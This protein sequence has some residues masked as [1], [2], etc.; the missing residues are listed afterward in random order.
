[1]CASGLGTLAQ[2]LDAKVRSDC[3]QLAAL[4]DVAHGLV[5]VGILVLVASLAWLIVQRRS[6]EPAH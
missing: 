6:P 3:S 1:M 4:D 5:V 2:A